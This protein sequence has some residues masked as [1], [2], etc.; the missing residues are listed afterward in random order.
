MK[1]TKEL[2]IFL[3]ALT[4]TAKRKTSYFIFLILTILVFLISAATFITESIKKELFITHEELP[5]IV[6]QK[7]IGG[8]QQYVPYS[9]ADKILD[10]P[11]L[12][13][14]TP[15]V[16]GYYYFDYAS[17]NFSIVGVDPL[18]PMY[19]KSLEDAFANIDIGKLTETEDW[20]ILGYGIAKLFDEIAYRNEAYFRK[21]DG[22]YIKFVPYKQLDKKSAIFNNDIVIISK[23]AARKLLGLEE[24]LYTDIAVN[25]YNKNEIVT[26]AAKIR[27]RLK[28]VRTITKK[29]VLNS[30]QN[31]FS[32]KTG[33]FIALF[34]ILLFTMMV[35]VIDKLSGLNESEKTEI[36]VF[37]T[38]GWTTF[39]ILKLK[40]Y[41]SF[42]IS[43]HAFI[44]GILI[45]MFYVFTFKAPIFIDMFTGYSSLKMQYNLIFVFNLK[46][47]FFIFISVVPFYVASVLIPS[48]KIATTDT[49]EVFR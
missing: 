30:Y 3:F 2:R 15:R 47:M 5:D 8:R 1:I 25:V 34:G 37:K 11:G 32:Y 36:G 49:Y 4:L 13:D 46:I 48:Y 29:D 24:N 21:P 20:M 40:L 31:V 41:E 16:W 27:D 17:V 26:I 28:D 43:F 7:V 38:V 39:D 9:Y 22:E 35:I 6:I 12:K 14:I 45:A 42:I 23:N 33:F 19:K 44:A 10:I 18:E